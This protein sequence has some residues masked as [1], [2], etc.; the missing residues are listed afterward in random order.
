MAKKEIPIKGVTSTVKNDSEYW[1]ARI[2]GEK[3]YCGKGGK[4]REIAIA[5]KAKYIASSYEQKEINTGLEVQKVE[6]K[7]IKALFNWYMETPKV[8]ALAGYQRKMLYSEF[9][10]SK[11]PLKSYKYCH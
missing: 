5:A 4:G 10:T 11:Q 2:D 6:F 3:K 8:Q 7:S 9:P 1:Y